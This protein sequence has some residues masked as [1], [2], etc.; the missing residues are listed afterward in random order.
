[1]IEGDR[2]TLE[3]EAEAILALARQR[4]GE[5]V[6]AACGTEAT[7]DSRFCRRCGAPMTGDVAELEVLRLTNGT[8]TG[9]QEV[10]A[11]AFTLLM[12][13]LLIAV[14]LIFSPTPLRLITPLLAAGGGI[15]LLM[16]F[17]G[18]RHTHRTLNPK[19]ERQILPDMRRAP[20]RFAPPVTASLQLPEAAP[21]VYSSVTEGTTELLNVKD[22][23]GRR[24]DERTV[25]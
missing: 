12:T 7:D 22:E 18:I 24:K 21:R 20:A 2:K 25:G 17:L 13:I 10:V 5:T 1:M 3:R 6:C 8:R 11:G 9:H 15:G 23:S 16:L 19:D 4:A 14:F